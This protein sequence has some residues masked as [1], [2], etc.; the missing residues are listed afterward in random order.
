MSL[1]RLK[2]FHKRGQGAQNCD[3]CEVKV[4]VKR[5][6]YYEYER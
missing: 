2:E 3:K 5:L 1:Q 6:V 4:N